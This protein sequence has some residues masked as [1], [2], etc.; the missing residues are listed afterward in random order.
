MTDTIIPSENGVQSVM[1][2]IESPNGFNSLGYRTPHVRDASGL[3]S[4]PYYGFMSTRTASLELGLCQ[5]LSVESTRQEPKPPDALSRVLNKSRGDL[6]HHP[7]QVQTRSR[8]DPSRK[9]YL[10]AK[11]TFKYT[12]GHDKDRVRDS[13]QTKPTTGAIA[14]RMIARR[15]GPGTNRTSFP[16]NS[17]R[18][19][20][21]VAR[22][23]Y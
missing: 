20:D 19:R 2:Y 1:G 18:G 21:Y 5:T 8:F 15:S 13:K 10:T 12:A 17:S 4:I 3:F 6:R 14:T 16:P 11:L 23:T 7:E 22:V 9:K